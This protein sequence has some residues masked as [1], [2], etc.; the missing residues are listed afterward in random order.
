MRNIINTMKNVKEII[1]FFIIIISIYQINIQKNNK[2]NYTLYI[3]AYKY[4]I[5]SLL[6]I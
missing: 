5:T 1:V 6:K 3:I 4:I 2:N